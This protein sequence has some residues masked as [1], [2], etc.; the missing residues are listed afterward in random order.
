MVF[1]IQ[2]WFFKILRAQ[3]NKGRFAPRISE[4]KSKFF[5][6]SLSTEASRVPGQIFF[7][8]PTPSSPTSEGGSKAAFRG[9]APFFFYARGYGLA[10]YFNEPSNRWI[11]ESAWWEYLKLAYLKAEEQKREKKNPARKNK[12]FLTM[13]LIY[14][15]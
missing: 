5:F 13:L 6:S 8:S 3:K 9:E 12:S 1:K 15:L 10:I 4:K 14:L 7:C 2:T 11:L